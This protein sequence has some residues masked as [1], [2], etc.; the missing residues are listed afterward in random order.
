MFVC[1]CLYMYNWVYFNVLVN[2]CLTVYVNVPL[3]FMPDLL[4]PFLS[5]SPA[6]HVLHLCASF[7]HRCLTTQASKH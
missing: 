7:I 3:F 1:I 6:K 2:S 4:S 5:F